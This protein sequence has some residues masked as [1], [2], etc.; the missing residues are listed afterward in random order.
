MNARSSLKTAFARAFSLVFVVFVV[1]TMGCG[2]HDRN[3][4]SAAC[5]T[6]E[7]AMHGVR[8]GAEGAKTGIY[9]GVEGVKAFGNAGAGLVEGGGKE[10]EQRWKDGKAKTKETAQEGSTA[11]KNE[12]NAQPCE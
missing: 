3:A 6:T 1:A 11:T 9:T 5:G 8:T 7:K 2:A 4:S 10:A 12:A